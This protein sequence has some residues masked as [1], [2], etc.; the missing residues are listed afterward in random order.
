M[1]TK[2]KRSGGF[3]SIFFMIIIIGIIWA[4]IA[5][6]SQR[7]SNYK[8]KNFVSDLKDNKITNVVI[9][10]NAEV[11]TG[12]LTI[13]FTDGSKD[14]LNV[15]DVISVQELLDDKNVEYAVKDVKRDSVWLTTILPFG[16]C[17]ILLAR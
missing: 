9:S 13:T 2:K 7:T 14:T 16:L 3:G 1:D 15:S 10:Q 8:Y 11:P 12:T 6:M 4:V 17:L 5:Q